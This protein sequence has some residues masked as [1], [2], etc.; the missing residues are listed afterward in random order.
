MWLKGRRN[1]RSS[2]KASSQ[3]SAFFQGEYKTMNGS[4]IF[5]T[6][7][8]ISYNWFNCWFCCLPL[9]FSSVNIRNKIH[10]IYQHYI[11]TFEDISKPKSSDSGPLQQEPWEE[12]VGLHCRR[13]WDHRNKNKTKTLSNWDQLNVRP[14]RQQCKTRVNAG[15]RPM[16][17]P[18][19]SSNL[20][21]ASPFC[22]VITNPC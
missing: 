19:Y 12:H 11:E 2:I 8:W 9:G 21:F 3:D 17:I 5:Y 14:R 20:L 1:K 18:P 22:P 10:D 15:T 16:Q 13:D 4:S 6:S 7:K